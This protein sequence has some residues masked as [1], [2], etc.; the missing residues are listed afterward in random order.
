MTKIPPEIFQQ[1]VLTWFD[2]NGRKNL[3]WQ[4]DISPYRIWLSEIMLQQTQVTTVIPYF[5]QFIQRFPDIYQLAKAPVDSVLQL[6]AGLGYYARARNLHKTAIIIAK[7]GA[8]F[9]NDLNSL[10]ELPGIGRST[11]GAILSIAFNNSHPILDGNVRR[12]L[13]RVHA[14]SGWT[15]STTVSHKLWQLSSL[16]T[17]SVRCA[18]YTQAMM[19]MGATLCTR[20]KPNCEL[21]PIHSHCDARINNLVSKIPS[22][23]PK[24]KLPIKHLVF[25]LLQNKDQQILLEKRPASGIWGG[26][27]SFPEFP[28]LSAAQSWCQKK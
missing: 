27:W 8:Q 15:S 1:K 13:A 12:V 23:K 26:L 3:P 9:P 25:L 11:A 7:N 18:D 2:T 14:I 16:Y 21:C 22:P 6:W 5:N 24:K 10:M 4:K 28:T 20:S 19:D 17:P